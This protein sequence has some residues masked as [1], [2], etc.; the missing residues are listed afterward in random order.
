MTLE[1]LQFRGTTALLKLGELLNQ[2][3]TA[4][5]EANDEMTDILIRIANT[6]DDIK[7]ISRQLYQASV[8]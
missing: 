6:Q 3:D 4:K 2:L 1:A 8:Y 7:R 5:D